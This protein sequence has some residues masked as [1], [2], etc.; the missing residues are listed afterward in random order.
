MDFILRGRPKLFLLSLTQVH[1]V[2]LGCSLSL[3][4]LL[5]IIIHTLDFGGLQCPVH[6]PHLAFGG[7]LSRLRRP[8][9][10]WHK[11]IHV[12]EIICL[13][14]YWFTVLIIC[15]LDLFSVGHT[16]NLKLGM[17]YG[18]RPVIM[19]AVNMS[20]MIIAFCIPVAPADLRTVLH[21]SN[22]SM[23]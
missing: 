3:V 14:N 10:K 23:A 21:G 17:R 5:S 9:E 19:S 4:S 1:L 18:S 20:L 2:F 15:F 16:C 7:L 8:R 22:M 11:Y 13:G 12:Y 6:G